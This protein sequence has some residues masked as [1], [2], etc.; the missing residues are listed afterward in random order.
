MRW[1]VRIVVLT[2]ALTMCLG[3]ADQKAGLGTW[4]LNVDKSDFGPMPP[5]KSQTMT[6]KEADGKI[7]IDNQVEGE[8]GQMDMHMVL[9]KGKDSVN[10]IMGMEFHTTLTDVADGQ[11]QETWAELPNGGGKFEM[12]S[13]SKVSDDGKV[14]TQ[15]VTMKSPMG[16]GTQKLVFN[17]Q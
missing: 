11:Q 16:E 12:K 4:K 17:K 15:D 8:M 9:E 6:V 14:L 13:I 10:E 5:T 7:V 1:S 3:A 2:V